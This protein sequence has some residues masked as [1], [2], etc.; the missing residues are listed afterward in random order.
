M[1]VI[2][3][4]SKRIARVKADLVEQGIGK[5]NQVS[6][7]GR[8]RYRGVDDTMATVAALHVKHGVNVSIT[9]IEDFGVTHSGGVH[10]CCVMT[11]AF[12]S[13]DNPQDAIIH[14]VIAE[15]KD[16]QDKASGKLHSYGY[17]NCMFS[18]YE[19]PVAGQ[20]I[21]GYDPRI[22]NEESDNAP[23]AEGDTPKE[24]LQSGSKS[25]KGSKGKGKKADTP[26][27]P[28][29]KT[30]EPPVQSDGGQEAG[31]SDFEAPE[32]PEDGVK[33]MK[34]IASL[35]MQNPDEANV[36]QLVTEA[37]WLRDNHNINGDAFDLVRKQAKLAH[38]ANN[39]ST[40]AVQA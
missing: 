37:R 28:E 5:N 32:T 40:Q 17:K 38:I 14:K 25:T 16:S 3:P 29:T 36:R 8:Y 19:I 39:N 10:M 18:F 6:G 4:V 7:G 26:S 27:V 15:G 13:S 33:R 12:Y 9:M 23:I 11:F 21:D 20:S 24:S 30:E 1:Q 31:D 22:D 35:I 34:K 2:L